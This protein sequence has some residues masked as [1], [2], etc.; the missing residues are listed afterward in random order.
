MSG[1][2]STRVKADVDDDP[3]FSEFLKSQKD[4]KCVFPR[5][6]NIF[7]LFLIFKNFRPRRGII[8]NVDEDFDFHIFIN[9]VRSRG[10]SL[11]SFRGS[12]TTWSFRGSERSWEG[13]MQHSGRDTVPTF[14]VV[15]ALFD[16]PASSSKL[17]KVKR[18]IWWN[19]QQG[20]G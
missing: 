14:F 13:D 7:S 3:G 5:F 10:D 12:S 11:C 16:F 6:F 17:R 19:W 15:M 1:K 9:K 8:R 18:R 20:E 4:S 2:I